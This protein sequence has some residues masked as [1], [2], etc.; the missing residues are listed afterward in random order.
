MIRLFAVC[1][2]LL[3]SVT[4]AQQSTYPGACDDARACPAGQIM[5]SAKKVCVEISA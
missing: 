2:C 3:P 1:L 4:L 5:D